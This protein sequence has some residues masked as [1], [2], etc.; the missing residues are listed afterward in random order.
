[1]KIFISQVSSASC[2]PSSAH[3]LVLFFKDVFVEDIDTSS[4]I[5]SFILDCRLKC[6]ILRH[7]GGL[8]I[9]NADLT[10]NIATFARHDVEP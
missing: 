9:E 4:L 5:L 10:P 2:F 8:K 7:F 1:M 6:H 3:L